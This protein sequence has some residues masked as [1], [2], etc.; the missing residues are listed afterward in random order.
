MQRSSRVM[1][2]VV[3]GEFVGLL[4]VSW[5]SATRG[6]RGS[7]LHRQDFITQSSSGRRKRRHVFTCPHLQ[8]VEKV[9]WRKKNRQKTERAEK[10]CD[11]HSQCDLLHWALLIRTD[12]IQIQSEVTRNLDPLKTDWRFLKF[13]LKQEVRAG[14]A[15]SRHGESNESGRLTSDPGSGSGVLVLVLGLVLLGCTEPLQDQISTVGNESFLLFEETEV[16]LMR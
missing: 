10:C 16:K 5:T 1:S 8:R 7:S 4:R 14:G 3:S 11:Q 12:V 6:Q 15:N 9:Q 13:Y 2:S